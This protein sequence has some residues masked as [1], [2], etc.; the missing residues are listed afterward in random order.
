MICP[1]PSQAEGIELMI[2]T[3][4]ERRYA[5]QGAFKALS[6]ALNLNGANCERFVDIRGFK[7][8]FPL[9]GGSP[10]PLPAFAK[11]SAEKRQAQQQHDLHSASCF[12]TL[13]NQLSG[14]RR[15]RLLGKFAEEDMAKLDRLLAL[16]TKYELAIAEAEANAA[17]GEAADG[18]ELEEVCAL[19]PR[20][21]CPES[22]M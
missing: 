16:H 12:S 19:L 9:I 4:K 3:V 14:E 21:F 5:S 7:T 17:H 20:D 10:P 8:L 1:P 15:Q 2:L 22:R 13:F 6:A 11:G 18:E